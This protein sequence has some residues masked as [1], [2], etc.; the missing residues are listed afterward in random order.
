MVETWWKQK[1]F[2][3]DGKNTKTVQKKILINQ[4]TMMVWS[5]TQSQTLWSVKWATGSTA[6]DTAG[7]CS[8]IPAELVKT[9]KDDVIRMLLSTC[10]QIWKTQ[11]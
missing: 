4:I 9:L 3:R 2:R 1:R 10:Q 5:V 8:G 7:G 6:V 11:Q